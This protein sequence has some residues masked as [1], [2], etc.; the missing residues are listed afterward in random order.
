MIFIANVIKSYSNNNS[1]MFYIDVYEDISDNI[2]NNFLSA[3]VYLNSL[4]NIF[5]I[6]N[7]NLDSTIIGLIKSIKIIESLKYN[8]WLYQVHNNTINDTYNSPYNEIK[9]TIKD[10]MKYVSLLSLLNIPS[11]NP[12]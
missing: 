3:K 12:W 1:P 4:R 6:G 2:S 10:K 11:R 8:E 9:V 5:G 7:L